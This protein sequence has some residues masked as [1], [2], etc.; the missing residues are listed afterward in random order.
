LEHFAWVNNSPNSYKSGWKKA[1]IEE[2]IN[3]FC[4][5]E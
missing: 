4:K 5:D 3:H 2:L 1:N